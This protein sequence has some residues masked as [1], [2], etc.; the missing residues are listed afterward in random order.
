[1]SGT[2]ISGSGILGPLGNNPGEIFE[3]MLRGERALKEIECFDTDGFAFSQGGEIQGFRP[4]EYLGKKGLRPLDRTGKFA[5]SA[6]GLALADTG[7]DQGFRESNEIS[8]VLGTN[9][10]SA[11]TIASFDQRG[12]EQ[13]PEYVSPLDFANTVI[14]AAAGQVAIRYKLRGTNST[15]AGGC[16][17]GL[18]ALAYAHELIAN[19]H[20][21]WVLA[22]GA[23]ELAQVSFAAYDKSAYMGEDGFFLSEGAAFT[24]LTPDDLVGPNPQLGRI[25]DHASRAIFSTEDSDGVASAI[26]TLLEDNGLQAAEIALVCTSAAG[27]EPVDV[28]ER[29]ALARVFDA[30]TAL[31]APKH[32]LGEGLGVSGALQLLLSLE[33]LKREEIPETTGT[34]RALSSSSGLALLL[35]LN[36]DGLL[37]MLLVQGC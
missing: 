35:G 23:E 12:L 15:T 4:I 13:G 33:A 10:C 8:L 14:N 34:S 27:Y 29:R 16:C 3:C 7:L 28:L 20:E 30:G 2:A 32:W 25:L 37:D 36:P 11:G 26:E 18:K 19:G 31:F 9:F 21:R 5:A 6:V 24:L 22:G 1:M 17:A